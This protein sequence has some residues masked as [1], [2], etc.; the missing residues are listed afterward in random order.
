MNP[1]DWYVEHRLGFVVR[2]LEPAEEDSFA[3][4]LRRCEECAAAVRELGRELAW[5]PMGARPARPRPGFRRLIVQ[6][7]LGEG[8]RSRWRWIGPLAAAASLTLAAGLAFGGYLPEHRE[9]RRLAG[10]L[11]LRSH[12]LDMLRDSLSVMREASRVLQATISM[13]GHQGGLLIFADD[14]THRWNV[15]LHG[16][17]PAPVGEAYQFWF[18]LANGM[19]R[20]ATLTPDPAHPAF[21]MLGMPERGGQVRGAALTMEASG[22]TSPEPRGRMLA[23]LTL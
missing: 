20:G 2:T 16:L 13:H 19:V 18:I 9:T 23:H 21:L 12:E 7:A 5:L 4:H 15:V 1:H 6:M 17:P 8:R 10:L 3:D 14:K 22:S 11:Q